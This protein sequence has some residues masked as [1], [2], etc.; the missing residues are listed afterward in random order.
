MYAASPARASAHRRR[1]RSPP[2]RRRRRGC[3][4]ATRPGSRDRRGSGL[5]R[6]PLPSSWSTSGAVGRTAPRKDDD[7][8]ADAVVVSLLPTGPAAQLTTR[9]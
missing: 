6:A 2:L 5:R 1:R 3:G 4:R 9:L 7:R 8:R